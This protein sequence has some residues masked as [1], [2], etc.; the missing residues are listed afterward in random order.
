MYLSAF[1][2]EITSV[3]G[4]IGGEIMISIYRW[5]ALLSL[6]VFTAF[7]VNTAGF[8]LR[9]ANEQHLSSHL[10]DEQEEKKLFP[11]TSTY[12]TSAHYHASQNT[13]LFSQ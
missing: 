5:R 8:A 10:E 1:Y 11:C 6:A 12:L 7:K 3:N 13:L 2:V 9:A 4:N